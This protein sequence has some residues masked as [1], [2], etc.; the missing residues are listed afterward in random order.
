M[1]AAYLLCAQAH[2][3]AAKSDPADWTP[4]YFDFLLE[5]LTHR[6]LSSELFRMALGICTDNGCWK[7]LNDA[8]GRCCGEDDTPLKGREMRVLELHSARDLCCA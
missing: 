7:C 6:D 5:E 1:G 3:L 4:A 2:A 8:I